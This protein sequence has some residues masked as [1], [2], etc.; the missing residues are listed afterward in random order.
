MTQ[1]RSLQE[2]LQGFRLNPKEED[3]WQNMSPGEKLK[4]LMEIHEYKRTDMKDCISL[5]ELSLV[6]NGKKAIGPTAAKRLAEKFK[7]SENFFLPKKENTEVTEQPK[8]STI[9]DSKPTTKGIIMTSQTTSEFISVNECK[10][11]ITNGQV[12][13]IYTNPDDSLTV[14]TKDGNKKMEPI[15]DVT[16]KLN[17]VLQNKGYKR[18]LLLLE[19]FSKNSGYVM[20]RVTNTCIIPKASIDGFQNVFGKSGLIEVKLKNGDAFNVGKLGLNTNDIRGQLMFDM[21]LR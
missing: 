19:V 8:E 16:M 21:G 20:P 7:R 10:S 6:L 9:V 4:K 15:K 3:I 17:G 2:Q 12:K 14:V 1:S 13:Y 5:P 11:L 18:M